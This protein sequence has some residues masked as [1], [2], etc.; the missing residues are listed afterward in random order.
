MSYNNAVQQLRQDF[1]EALEEAL[2]YQATDHQR[3]ARLYALA[4]EKQLSISRM[5]DSR[6]VKANCQRIICDLLD[7]ADQLAKPIEIGEQGAIA[8][9]SE[10]PPGLKVNKPADY[11]KL[12]DVQ[13]MEKEK[14]MVMARWILPRKYPDLYEKYHYENQSGIL[15]V[16]PAGC[17]KSFF[18]RAVANSLGAYFFD[19]HLADILQ[20]LLGESDKAI[21]KLFA[22]ARRLAKLGHFVCI[23][24]DEINGLTSL[25]EP[26]G[27]PSHIVMSFQSEIDSGMNE[28]KNILLIGSTNHIDGASE[29]IK[30]P[31]RFGTPI[32][33]SFPDYKTRDLLIRQAIKDNP[34]ANDFDYELFARRTEGFTASDICQMWCPLLKCRTAGIEAMRCEHD[35]G[36]PTVI[37]ITNRDLHYILDRMKPSI[38]Y[39]DRLAW[40]RLNQYDIG[41]LYTLQNRKDGI[42]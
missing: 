34:V 36:T 26:N 5:S 22:E 33:V 10:L 35:G 14:E 15:M 24:F 6:E 32:N 25:T 21:R 18:G 37:P 28:N 8:L 12:E 30:R 27:K 39:E 23:Y 17:G 4:A 3:A 20:S 29:A 19:V 1:S 13:G 40:N 16:G 38:A 7:R 9:S 41:D 42:L 31:G 2:H 11:P